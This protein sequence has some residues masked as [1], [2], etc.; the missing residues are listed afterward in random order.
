MHIHTKT[1]LETEKKSAKVSIWPRVSVRLPLRTDEI[2]ESQ[3][4]V[5]R[6]SW[7][8]RSR[9]RWQA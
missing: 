6:L 5:S 1:A 4:P 8:G 2:V 7:A 3:M 9:Y